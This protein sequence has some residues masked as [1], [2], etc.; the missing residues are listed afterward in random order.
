M[1]PPRRRPRTPMNRRTKFTLLGTLSLGLACASQKPALAPVVA[2][3][4]PPPPSGG[5]VSARAERM[6]NDANDLYAEQDKLGAIN[7]AELEYRYQESAGADTGFAE[8]EY[9][10]GLLYQREGKLDQA[11][12]AF[13]EALR[14]RPR[15]TIAAEGLAML[16]EAQGQ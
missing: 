8:P 5:P 11:A 6:F 3:P 13:Q 12:Q 1:L 9:N 2:A 15:L 14:R 4:P 16:K 10:L 7:Y